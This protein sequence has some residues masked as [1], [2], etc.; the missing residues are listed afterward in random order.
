M[1]KLV[2]ISLG[3]F[4]I[5]FLTQIIVCNHMTVKTQELNE[6]KAQ[7]TDIQ[8]QISV[9]NQEIYLA[10]SITG[11][12]DRARNQGFSQMETPVKSVINPTIARVF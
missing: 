6:V 9:I 1:T 2:K 3:I 10:S 4:V 8:N 12:E 11:M 7:V 5:S